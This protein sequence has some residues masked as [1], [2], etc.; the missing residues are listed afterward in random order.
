[1][2][3]CIGFRSRTDIASLNITNN[4]QILL[5]AILYCSMKCFQSRQ[6]K[7]F[8]HSN[9]RLYS[10]N[11][12][13]NSIYNRLVELPDGFSSTFQC[14]TIFIKRLLLNMFRYKC[15]IRIQSDNDWCIQFLNLS[16]QFIN[17]VRYILL[18]HNFP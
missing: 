13:I 16:H 14:L 5:T 8:I 7:L 12:I 10:R 11:Q 4:N 3:S 17:H 6:P 15:Q 1:M 9:L 18:K 2:A